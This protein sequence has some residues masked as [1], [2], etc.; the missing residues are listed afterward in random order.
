MGQMI[1]PSTIKPGDWFISKKSSQFY[2]IFYQFIIIT[3]PSNQ[4][5]VSPLFRH[6]SFFQHDNFVGISHRTQTMSHHNHRSTSEK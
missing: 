2:L 3:F 5:L 6:T 4:L 1:N